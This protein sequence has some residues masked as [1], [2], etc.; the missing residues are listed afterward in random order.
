MLSEHINKR[1]RNSGSGLTYQLR[2]VIGNSYETYDQCRDII[3]AIALTT[4]VEVRYYPFFTNG[5]VYEGSMCYHY[6]NIFEPSRQIHTAIP[7]ANVIVKGVYGGPD[8]YI[9]AEFDYT[10]GIDVEG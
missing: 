2:R 9:E 10:D 8:K 3:R 4:S 6:R 1:L 7:K 5:G